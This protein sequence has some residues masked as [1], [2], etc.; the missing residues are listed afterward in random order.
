MATPGWQI[1]AAALLFVVWTRSLLA[2]NEKGC[3]GLG[4]SKHAPD[5]YS[6]GNLQNRLQSDPRDVNALIDLGIHLEEQG[7]ILEANALYERAIQAKPDCYLG[8]YFSG[9]AGEQIGE[10]ASTQAEAKIRKALSLNPSLRHDGNVQS[11]MVRHSPLAGHPPTSEKELPSPSEELLGTANRF[12][13][14]VGVGLLLAAPLLY[15][16]RRKR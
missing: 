2:Q 3:E 13:V 5:Q 8:Y 7:Q 15:L 9:L 14:G 1:L 16:A 11:F 6:P 10:Q 4:Y 12:V